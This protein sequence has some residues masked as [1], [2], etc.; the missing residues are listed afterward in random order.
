MARLYDRSGIGKHCH[1]TTWEMQCSGVQ[2]DSLGDPLFATR[3]QWRLRASD[4][5]ETPPTDL[6]LI[7]CVRRSAV[8]SRFLVCQSHKPKNATKYMYFSEH[9]FAVQKFNGRHAVPAQFSQIS[10]PAQLRHR[11]IAWTRTPSLG[12][13]AAAHV[14]FIYFPQDVVSQAS[15]ASPEMSNYQWHCMPVT[16]KHSQSSNIRQGRPFS[17][18]GGPN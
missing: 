18:Q 1:K 6:L 8:F 15:K 7:Y 17:I 4:I 2:R 9:S 16:Q 3:G 10:P 12:C 13:W 14:C 11:R 5:D